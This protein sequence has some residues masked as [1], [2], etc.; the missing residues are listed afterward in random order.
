[1]SMFRWQV[2]TVTA[3]VARPAGLALAAD[4]LITRPGPR[5]Y[6]TGFSPAISHKARKQS[7]PRS[8][9]GAWADAA[10]PACPA[11]PRRSTP[12]YEAGS[13]MTGRGLGPARCPLK[14]RAGGG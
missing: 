10:A 13:T 1:M 12:R 6:F 7:A 9:P 4:A 2:P 8:E 5:G 14:D 3:A 11:L